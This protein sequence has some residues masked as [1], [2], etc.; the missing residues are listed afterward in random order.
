LADVKFLDDICFDLVYLIRGGSE[1]HSIFEAC[2]ILHGLQVIEA[3]SEAEI[4]VLVPNAH[5]RETNGDELLLK[6]FLVLA[7]VIRGLGRSD[8][9]FQAMLLKHYIQYFEVL[10]VLFSS[11]DREGKR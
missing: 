1:G 8:E 3:I 2:L 9:G 11:P 5:I 4:V 7:K 10:V 6:P